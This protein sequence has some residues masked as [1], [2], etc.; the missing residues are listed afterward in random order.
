VRIA[1]IFILL[2]SQLRAAA[3][4]PMTLISENEAEPIHGAILRKE[5]WTQD[6]VRRL[7]ADADKRLTQGPW[8]VTASRPKNIELDLHDY[9]S[10]APYFWPDPDHPGGPY[11]RQDG[12]A[13]PDRFM[14]NKNGL[15]AMA[16]AV[17]SLG[18]AAFLLDNASYAQ[19]S[20]RIVNVWFVNPRTRMNPSLEYSQAIPGT[21]TGRPEG[22]LDGRVLIRAIQGMEF[23]A[24]TGSWDAK[25]QAAVHKWF[26]DYLH[27]L[28]HSR[29]AEDEKNSGN[30]HASWWAAQLAAVANFVGD[31]AAQ[32][33]A[34]SFY[35]DNIFPRQIRKD[36]SAPREEARTRSLSYSA[37]NLEAFAMLC[38]IAQV[39]GVDLW[40]LQAKNG[41]TIAT[42]IDYLAPAFADPH[43]WS[44]EQIVDFETAGLYSLAFAGIGLKRPDYVALFRKLERPEGA[45]MAFVDLIVGRWESSGRR[46]GR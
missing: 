23:L 17:F 32:Q 9:Y 8:T 22:V 16:D 43:K 36:G 40:T 27:W 34:F 10:E 26:E 30:N 35:R 6:A 31:A 45:W 28:T 19:R 4:M 5:A 1:L 12:R 20:A 33:S 13:N 39:Q 42:V 2:A 29:T 44:S 46:N 21:N 15:N 11:I 24:A 7:R 38:R 14:D 3:D 41:A 37:F 18:T 25:D